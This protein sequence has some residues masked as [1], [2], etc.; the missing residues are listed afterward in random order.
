VPVSGIVEEAVVERLEG[1][2]PGRLRAL[3]AA[4]VVGVGAALLTYRLLRA[5]GTQDSGGPADE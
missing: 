5:D 4:I 1:D 3:A 2:E